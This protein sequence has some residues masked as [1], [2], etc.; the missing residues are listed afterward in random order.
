MKGRINTIFCG[1]C[2]DEVADNDRYQ[3]HLYSKGISI[4]AYLHKSCGG[5]ID[6]L[7]E[8]VWHFHKLSWTY[9]KNINKQDTLF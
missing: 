8:N 3:I 2:Q 1:Y 7:G 4:P 5:K 9:Q 6:N